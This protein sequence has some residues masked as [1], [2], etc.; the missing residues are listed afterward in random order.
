[1]R[2]SPK[3]RWIASSDYSGK[4]QVF[5]LNGAL[6]QEPDP[7]QPFLELAGSCDAPA[8]SRDERLMATSAAKLYRTGAKPGDWQEIWSNP[9][10]PTPA[11]VNYGPSDAQFSPDQKQLLVSRC[12]GICVT[13]LLSVATGAV[14]RSLPELEGPH[15]SFSPEGSWIVAANKLLHLPSGEVRSLA[16][17]ADAT[18]PAIFTPEGDIIAGSPDGTLTRYCRSP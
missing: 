17:N 1:M 11:D 16:P 13:H 6:S 3:A 7:W 14:I 9:L 15:P 10:P 12:R 5:A 8:F 4:L 18:S 2:L